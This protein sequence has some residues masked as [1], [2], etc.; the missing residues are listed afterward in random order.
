MSSWL[1]LSLYNNMCNLKQVYK[2]VLSLS[3]P[4]FLR[5]LLCFVLLRF[6]LCWARHL[7]HILAALVVHSCDSLPSMQTAY[8]RYF[9]LAHVSWHQRIISTYLTTYKLCRNMF[10]VFVSIQIP[11]ANLIPE[12]VLLCSLSR[13]LGIPSLCSLTFEFG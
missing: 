9:Y 7:F 11:G 8:P 13:Q 4:G 2:L 6:T 12:L 1:F 3:G 5:R 10:L